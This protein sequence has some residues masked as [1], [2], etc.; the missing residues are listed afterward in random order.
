MLRNGIP[1]GIYSLLPSGPSWELFPGSLALA[2][3]AEVLDNR[4]PSPEEWSASRKERVEK[5]QDWLCELYA[6]SD[7][8]PPLGNPSGSY[9][10]RLRAEVARRDERDAKIHLALAFCNPN[11]EHVV[12]ARRSRRRKRGR[13]DT[14][15]MMNDMITAYFDRTAT[16]SNLAPFECMHTRG[17]DSESEHTEPYAEVSAKSV[18]PN[19]SP[20]WLQSRRHG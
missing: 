16:E 5:V 19:P 20:Y 10:A 15:R 6:N 3:Q 2:R 13:T 18:Q 14:Y 11:R 17:L 9:L 1:W 8:P 4:C 7:A 12:V